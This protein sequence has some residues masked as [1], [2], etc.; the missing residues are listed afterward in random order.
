MKQ[1]ILR[2]ALCMLA[3]TMVIIFIYLWH[4]NGNVHDKC[5]NINNEIAILQQFDWLK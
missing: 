5:T 1:F 3:F 4:V 2:Y